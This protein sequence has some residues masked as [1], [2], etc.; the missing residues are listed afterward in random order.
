METLL[1]MVQYLK[2]YQIQLDVVLSSKVIDIKEKEPTIHM[3]LKNIKLSKKWKKL[4]QL[5][6]LTQRD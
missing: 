3:K 6:I 2:V 1:Q 5:I 4:S